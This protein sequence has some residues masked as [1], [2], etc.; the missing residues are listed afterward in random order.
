MEYIR[1]E[2]N[3]GFH[4]DAGLRLQG[5]GYIRGLYNYRSASAPE[6]NSFRLYFRGEYG[7]GRLNYPLFPGTTIE[8]FDT[9]VLRAGMNDHSNPFIKDELCRQL[10]SDLGM[11]ASHGTFVQPVSQRGLRGLLQSGG[12]HRR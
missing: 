5:G 12:A 7:Q 6:G 2:D 8:S 9:L 10:S 11:A 4:V 3:G 1:P